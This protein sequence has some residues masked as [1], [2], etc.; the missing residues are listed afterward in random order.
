RILFNELKSGQAVVVD[1]EGDPNDI[2]NA[3]LVF[4]AVARETPAEEPVEAT[5]VAAAPTESAA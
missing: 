5:A 1:C 4:R 2:E 3:K